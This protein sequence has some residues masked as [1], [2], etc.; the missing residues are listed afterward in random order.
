M[1]SGV[2]GVAPQQRV[3]NR[4]WSRFFSVSLSV[5]RQS[6][7]RWAHRQPYYRRRT[8]RS[9]GREGNFSAE[10]VLNWLAGSGK[11]LSDRLSLGSK[12]AKQLECLR[13]R[14]SSLC[15]RRPVHGEISTNRCSSDYRSGI[16]C[17]SPQDGPF[18]KHR[19]AIRRGI[20]L[21]LFRGRTTWSCT[22]PCGQH[23][24]CKCVF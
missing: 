17:T 10:A 13:F 2:V 24:Q 18:Y 5:I 9:L 20:E 21:C 11:I 7:Q 4:N 22:L 8:P 12:T 3:S 15:W 1:V 23:Y 14:R 6:A 16:A 19:D